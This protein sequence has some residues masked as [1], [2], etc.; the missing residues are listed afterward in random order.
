M[1]TFEQYINKIGSKLGYLEF[2]REQLPKIPIADTI[3]CDN[4]ESIDKIVDEIDNS[5]GWPVIIRPSLPEM[6]N[7]YDG[8]FNTEKA[9]NNDKTV[10]KF[11]FNNVKSVPMK[12]R[13]GEWKELEKKLVVGI[14][15]DIKPK[16]SGLMIEHPNFSDVYLIT[17][18]GISTDDCTDMIPRGQYIYTDKKGLEIFEGFHPTFYPISDTPRI[19]EG[20]ENVIKWAKEIS[21]L[22]R[23]NKEIPKLYEFGIEPDY[24]FEVKDLVY[25]QKKDSGKIGDLINDNHII[26]GNIPTDQKFSL[27]TNNDKKI[28]GKHPKVRFGSIHHYMMNREYGDIAGSIV[29]NSSA[30]LSHDAARIIRKSPWTIFYAKDS[31]YNQFK[32]GNVMYFSEHGKMQKV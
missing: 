26:I 13:N 4:S 16:Y 32:H 10:F 15:P 25:G 11:K 17:I 18:N 9:S 8:D 31:I 22:E 23:P 14:S 29:T 21:I 7:G 2:I 5:M 24:L 19:R 28:K 1:N 12:C 27:K 3:I 20:I 30:F 6:L